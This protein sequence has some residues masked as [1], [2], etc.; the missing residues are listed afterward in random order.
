MVNGV[1]AWHVQDSGFVGG[2]EGVCLQDWRLVGQAE[3]L[4]SG[5]GGMRSESGTAGATDQITGV[6]LLRVLPEPGYRLVRP[7]RLTVYRGHDYYWATP[8]HF[9]LHGVGATPEEAIEDYAC[10]LVEYYEDLRGLRE[11][12]APHLVEHLEFLEDIIAEE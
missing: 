8:D 6:E 1:L 4:D 7:L 3:C 12:L 9:P 10:A 11:N 5:T 2:L